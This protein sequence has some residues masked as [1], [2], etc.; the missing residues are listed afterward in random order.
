MPKF[1]PLNDVCACS[2]YQSQW[3]VVIFFPFST[4]ADGNGLVAA[5]EYWYPPS[6]FIL[7]QQQQQWRFIVLSIL[8]N[9]FGRAPEFD[10]YINTIYVFQDKRQ[11]TSGNVKIRLDFIFCKLV[12]RASPWYVQY[13]YTKSLKIGPMRDLIPCI[14]S[15]INTN[16]KKPRAETIPY[17]NDWMNE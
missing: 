1:R 6:P 3:K 5:G 15:F 7:N 9:V 10:T 14:Q 4:R 11:E 12:V 17:Q 16:G 2:I 8:F 13:T